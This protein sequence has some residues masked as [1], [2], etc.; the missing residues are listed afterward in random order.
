MTDQITKNNLVQV[1]TKDQAAADSR[2]QLLST[3][4]GVLAT[5]MRDTLGLEGYP[6]GSVVPFCLNSRGEP[7]L[8]ISDL[9]Q[10]T[11]N[12]KENPKASLMI[13]NIDQDNIQKGWR[14]TVIG[15]ITPID[16][17]EYDD[18]AD[19]YERF[20]GESRRYHE[21]HDFNFY[22]LTP[23]KY[24]YIHGFGEIHWV[25]TERVLQPSPFDAETEAS[26]IDHMNEDHHDTIVRFMKTRVEVLP[27]AEL[28]MVAI[29]QYGFIIAMGE[30]LHRFFFEREAETPNDIRMLLVDMAK[31]V[32]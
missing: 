32:A 30:A 13:H 4:N 31:K 22:Q 17:S 27:N 2:E 16:L 1:Y 12:L 26:M 9:A 10:H 7:I 24:R 3:F 20:F 14:L 21:V 29:D 5:T 15:D 19:R 25:D 6:F 23:K 11:K 8:L 18:I 28:K